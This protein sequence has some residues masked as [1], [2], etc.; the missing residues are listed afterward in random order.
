MPH[1]NM[2]NLPVEV[3]IRGYSLLQTFPASAKP[4]QLEI[5]ES[6]LFEDEERVQ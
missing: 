5:T 3:D 1:N 6:L 4:H 2:P